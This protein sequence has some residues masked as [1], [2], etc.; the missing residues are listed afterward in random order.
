M[1]KLLLLLV[2]VVFGVGCST[3]QKERREARDRIAGQSGLLCDFVNESD[4][5]DVDV[6]LNLRMANKCNAVKPFSISGYKRL[7]DSAGFMFCCSLKEGDSL[8]GSAAPR[9][10]APAVQSEEAKDAGTATQGKE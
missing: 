10:S 1:N 4:Y 3:A 9:S 7:N 2:C 6:E 8:S 5:K